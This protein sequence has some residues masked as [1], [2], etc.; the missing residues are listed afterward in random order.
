[1]RPLGGA[2]ER[3]IAQQLGQRHLA[4]ARPPSRERTQRQPKAMLI[5]V[6]SSSAS[7]ATTPQPTQALLFSTGGAGA[8][9]ERATS[10]KRTAVRSRT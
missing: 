10:G 2:F 7:G 1:M 9:L 5:K 6:E 4:T 8:R 3:W